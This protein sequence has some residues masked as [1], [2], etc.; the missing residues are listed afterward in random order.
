[1]VMP[2]EGRAAC[3]MVKPFFV[4]MHSGSGNG[5][6]QSAPIFMLCNHASSSAVGTG[7]SYQ[8]DIM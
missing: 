2:L 3:H 5:V 7:N 8:F 4:S 6:R 1:M